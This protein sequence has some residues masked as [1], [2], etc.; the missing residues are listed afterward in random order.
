MNTFKFRFI[1]ITYLYF[2]ISQKIRHHLN[3][4]PHFQVVA[5]ALV[6]IV[7]L[8]A[9]ITPSLACE[10]LPAIR[11]SN[12]LAPNVP[13]NI[14]RNPYFCSLALFSIVSQIPYINKPNFFRD[15]FIS[16]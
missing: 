4:C 13:N 15:T 9:Q 7:P 8:P 16:R 3:S 5:V 6:L 1:L 14:L 2:K 12:K 11:F 10:S